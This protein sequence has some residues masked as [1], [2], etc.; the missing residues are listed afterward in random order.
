MCAA[1]VKGCAAEA[2]AAAAA[3][4]SSASRVPDWTEASA[5]SLRRLETGT[6]MTLFYQKKSQ[7]PERRTFQVKADTRLIVWSR[8]SDKTE[9]EGEYEQQA[10][11]STPPRLRRPAARLPEVGPPLVPLTFWLSSTSVHVS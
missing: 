9:G 2:A 8:N 6:A 4:P 11:A 7:R 5:H 10:H 3:G 1:R